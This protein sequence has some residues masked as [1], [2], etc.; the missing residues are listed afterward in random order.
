[1]KPNDNISVEYIQQQFYLDDDGNVRNKVN[2]GGNAHKAL[3]LVNT[4]AS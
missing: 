2:R 1:M 4:F 3:G